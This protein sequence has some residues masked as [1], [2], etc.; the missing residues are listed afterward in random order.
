MIE[1][2]E[3]GAAVPQTLLHVR[4]IGEQIAP[5][6]KNQREGM[7]GDRV[8][9]IVTNVGDG[10]AVVTTVAD[11]DHVVAGGGNRDHAQLR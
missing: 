2:T 11:I 8:H 1:Q 9:R 4:S 3:F 5:Q 7:L 6:C 10:H